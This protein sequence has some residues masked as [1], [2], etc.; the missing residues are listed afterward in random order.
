MI[1]N[2]NLLIQKKLIR[3]KYLMSFKI[4]EVQKPYSL[5]IKFKATP[6]IQ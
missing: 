1:K 3:K 4:R 5:G 2:F 6:L